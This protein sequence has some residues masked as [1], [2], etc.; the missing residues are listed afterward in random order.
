MLETYMHGY[1]EMAV[2]PISSVYP[3]LVLIGYTWLL[4]QYPLH[5]I[6][7]AQSI[8]F[9][10]PLSLSFA[11]YNQDI[12][13]MWLVVWYDLQF[14]LLKNLHSKYSILVPLKRKPCALASKAYLHSSSFPFIRSRDS[15]TRTIS[16]ANIDSKHKTL[17]KFMT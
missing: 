2:V 16:F 9:N 8:W 14:I 12:H 4:T 10:L 13:T 15:P 7:S 17:L 6:H 3:V 1:S 11:W 5:F